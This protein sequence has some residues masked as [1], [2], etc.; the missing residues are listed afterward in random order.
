[1]A[2]QRV[3]FDIEAN[4]DPAKRALSELDR[5]F[6][7]TVDSLKKKQ[8]DVALFKA[9]QQ[10]AAALE[11]QIK[12]LAKAGGDTTALNTALAAQR[13][14]IAQQATALRP[15]AS[16]PPPWQVN[17][18][19]CARSWTSPPDHTASNPPPLPPR[20]TLAGSSSRP[21]P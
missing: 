15:P 14:S 1:M 20:K 18:P 11:R 21:P 2:D 10:D 12:A 5:A 9:A 13:A 16:I 3:R 6:G 4:A 17:R 7:K 8:A 19:N